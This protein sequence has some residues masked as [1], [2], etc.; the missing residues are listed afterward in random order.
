MQVKTDNSNVSVWNI[1]FP[2]IVTEALSKMT[3]EE[4]IG[5]IEINQEEKN[6]KIEFKITFNPLLGLNLDFSVEL[7]E[8]KSNT[9]LVRDPKNG[10]KIDGFIA[11]ECY[12]KPVINEKYFSYIKNKEKSFRPKEIAYIDFEIDG[13]QDETD[14]KKLEQE[15]KKRKEMIRNMR[16][17]RY[18]EED[19]LNLIF[20]C[21]EKKEKWT[22]KGLSEE[23]QQPLAY[24]NDLLNEVAIKCDYDGNNIF[25]KLNKEFKK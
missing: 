2:K 17:V 21:F 11:K 15:H 8:F 25:Y 23:M 13:I 6:G 22:A 19:A 18:S 1:K 16:T 14:Y 4:D 24:I 7:K 20:R 12:I 9:F 5:A 10:P 3:E